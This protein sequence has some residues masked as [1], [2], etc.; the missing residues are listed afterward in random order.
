ML[1]RENR[2][3][4]VRR[5]YHKKELGLRRH[6]LRQ[7][8]YVD[9]VIGLGLQLVVNHFDSQGWGQ[10]LE[11]GIAD[12]RDQNLIARVGERHKNNE[13][14]LVYAVLDGHVIDG[15]WSFG[16]VKF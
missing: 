6:Q 2:A 16:L 12:F 9:F 10:L 7:M 11:N 14:S 4:W 3:H 13:E 8:L 1:Q 15:H 5:V